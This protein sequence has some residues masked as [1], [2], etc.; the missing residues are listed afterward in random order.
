MLTPA[1]WEQ[2]F[3]AELD[4]P[5]RVVY[6]RA[7]RTVL[8]VQDLCVAPRALRRPPGQGLLLRMSSFFAEAPDE[9][10]D[11][12]VRWIRSGRRARRTNRMLDEWTHA[13]I[14]E[15]SQEAPRPVRA[16]PR[17]EHHDLAP[18]A[19]E[20]RR[21]HFPTELP[22]PADV[23]AIT[24]G[25]RG[26]SRTR[27]SLQLG[28]FDF[29]ARVVRIHRVLDQPAVPAWFV[30]YVLFHELLHAALEG[31]E[32]DGAR[33]HGPVFRA[34][35]RRYPDYAAALAWEREHL[36]A[37]IRSARTGTPIS[38]RRKTLRRMWQQLDLFGGR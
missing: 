5:V 4:Y 13:R 2:R 11:A 20:L 10:Q 31:D 36:G 18:L 3:R 21:E 16:E 34:R 27:R 33:H 8:R 7:R 24:W 6:S 38:P 37:L 28:I 25:K 9:I 30:R 29:R 15:L 17:G 19:R 32:R 26:R 14:D 23:P 22:T 35:E 12:V 1:D